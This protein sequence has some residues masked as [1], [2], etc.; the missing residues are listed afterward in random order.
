MSSLIA[1]RTQPSNSGLPLVTKS[2]QP[3]PPSPN[4]LQAQAEAERHA[5]LERAWKHYTGEIDGHFRR[6][7][8]QPDPNVITNRASTIVDT[9]VDFLY[10]KTVRLEVLHNGKPQPE[11]QDV[12]DGCWG[13]DDRRM[14]LMSKLAQNGGI[15]GHVFAKIIPPNPQRQR[16]FCRVVV[17][18]PAQVSV[19][20]DPD[21]CDTVLA[22]V[23]EYTVPGSLSPVQ[24]QLGLT[25]G[26]RQVIVRVDPDDD[27]DD[28]AGGLDPDST[29][30][31]STWL[32]GPNNTWYQ[33]GEPQTWA[34]PWAPIVDWQNLPLA[35]LHWGMSDIPRNLQHL[36]NV[37]NLTLSN[38]NAI[39]KHH[40]FPW[41]YASGVGLGATIELA[42]GKIT[43]LQAPEGKLAAVEA[44]GDL[45]GLLSFA[46][47]VRSDMDEQSRVPAV[48]TGRMRDLP[49]VTSGVAFQ[50]M[51]GPLLA[52]NTHKQRLYGM[53]H[54][55]LSLRML[56]L[57]GYGDGTGTDGWEVV[58]HWP[59]PLP[60][61]DQSTAQLVLAMEQVGTSQHAICSVLNLDYEQEQEYKRQ[62][63]KEA[64]QAMLQGQALPAAPP[65]PSPPPA[66]ASPGSAA[67]E[68]GQTPPAQSGTQ[69]GQ[70]PTNHPA[71][72]AQRQATAAVAKAMKGGAR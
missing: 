30:E 59:S 31:I 51:Y 42:P 2:G 57:C 71:A 36:N 10:G 33:Q 32:R 3:M 66:P 34:H 22:Y 20:T 60:N 38:I 56:S 44:H 61:D 16:P 24:Q 72:I 37:L 15:F 7:P 13:N 54:E 14:T 67:G 1:S 25:V 6:E 58:T 29:W 11:A 62:E 9:G 69:P 8:G 70:P 47:D 21:D 46:A 55:E 49:K 68:P 65:P 41:L 63:A 27:A 40:S 53:G 19:V 4:Y 45:A 17:L 5:A 26:K 48:A 23:I 52:K 28:Y 50:M 64:M 39:A 12:L 43:Q 35:N 18:D